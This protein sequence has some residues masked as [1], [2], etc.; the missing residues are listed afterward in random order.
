MVGTITLG[1][2]Q[3]VT[4]GAP[5]ACSIQ[6]N[7][8]SPNVNV[9]VTVVQTHGNAPMWGGALVTIAVGPT[10]SGVGAIPGIIIPTATP[11]AVLVAT[12]T[13]T[14]AADVFAPDAAGFRVI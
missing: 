11:A 1:A 13:S 2:P 9:D 6:I 12:A 8:A 10:G 14:V 3:Q 5:F 7:G 4:H